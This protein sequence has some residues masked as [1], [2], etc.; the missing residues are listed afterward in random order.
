[1]IFWPKIRGILF[2][3]PS[4]TVCLDMS[5]NQVIPAKLDGLSFSLHRKFYNHSS[6]RVQDFLGDSISEA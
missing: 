2:L 4:E 6:P 1:M 5:Q 3:T